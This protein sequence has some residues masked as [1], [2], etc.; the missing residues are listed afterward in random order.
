[1]QG[2]YHATENIPTHTQKLSAVT[3]NCCSVELSLD[4]CKLDREVT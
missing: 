3:S 2:N 1:M 4:Y